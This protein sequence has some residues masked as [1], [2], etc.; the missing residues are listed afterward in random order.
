MEIISCCGK[1]MSSEVKFCSNCGKDLI[2]SS[3]LRKK[4]IA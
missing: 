1:E 4:Q 2:K 3:R